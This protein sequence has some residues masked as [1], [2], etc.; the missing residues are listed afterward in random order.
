MLETDPKREAG[1]LILGAY[2]RLVENRGVKPI[3]VVAED[4]HE[5][6]ARRREGKKGERAIAAEEEARG[7]DGVLKYEVPGLG[8]LSYDQYRRVGRSP[9]IEGEGGIPISFVPGMIFYGLMINPRGAVGA[10]NFEDERSMTDVAFKVQVCH[11]R[12]ILGDKRIGKASRNAQFL[13]IH[14]WG[15]GRYSLTP[16]TARGSRG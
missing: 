15:D 13:L 11:L 8:I 12:S 1:V 2:I 9:L 7:A 10:E 6:L 14:N 16:K 4:L 5:A 3:D